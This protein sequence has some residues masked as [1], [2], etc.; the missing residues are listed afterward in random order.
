MTVVITL[1]MSPHF[2]LIWA[3]AKAMKK[4]DAKNITILKMDTLS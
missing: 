4:D 1:N 3:K 2:G